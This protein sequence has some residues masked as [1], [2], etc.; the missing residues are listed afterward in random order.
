MAGV[1][2]VKQLLRYAIERHRLGQ[3]L[4]VEGE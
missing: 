2:F 3:T 4:P 1:H